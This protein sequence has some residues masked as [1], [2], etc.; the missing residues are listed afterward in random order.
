MITLYDPTKFKQDN[1]YN[2]RG[3]LEY[4]LEDKQMCLTLV[5]RS[6][7]CGHDTYFAKVPHHGYGCCHPMSNTL[8]LN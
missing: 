6:I 8:K 1:P 3:L 5:I 2:F 7:P 4:K